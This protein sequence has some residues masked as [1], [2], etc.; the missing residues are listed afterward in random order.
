MITWFS[1][2]FA[3]SSNSKGG[4]EQFDY[5][6]VMVATLL[7]IG[8]T[9]FGISGAFGVFL[10]PLVEDF[11]S[12][13]V[14]TSGIFSVYIVLGAM[15]A[16]L[17]GW[18]LDRYGAKIIVV[19]MG[20]FI[21]LSLSLTSQ[22]NASWQLF[23]SYSLLFAMGVGPLYTLTMSTVSRWFSRRRVLAIGIVGSGMGIGPMI[24]APVSAWLISSYD[25][26]TAYFSMGIIA[27]AI[28]IPCALLLK[29]AP[30]ELAALPE[31]GSPAT[32]KLDTSEQQ[33][34]S[35]REEFSLSQAVKTR[36]F[37]LLFFIWF[38]M[39]F[40]FLMVLT[41]LV[42]HAMD[43]GIT[44]MKAASILSLTTGLSIAGRV[45]ISKVSD[46]IGR[47]QAT[48]GCALLMAGA[49]LFLIQ[50]PNLTVLYLF[51]IVFGLTYGGVGPPIV[52]Q[53]GDI[54]GLRNIGII[55]GVLNVGW[56]AG[57]ASGAALGGYVFDVSGSYVSAFLGAMAAMVIAAVLIL[58][59][60]TPTANPEMEGYH[61]IYQKENIVE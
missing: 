8:I 53:F 56:G 46:I 34:Y 61:G 3:G 26:R 28:I 38:F 49:L 22:A 30:L 21:G 20:F 54:F 47:K 29:K 57:A 44:P 18:A 10:K 33:D 45:M 42:P 32:N 37:W 14:L 11:S 39:A 52:A 2:N 48:V 24:M 51:A 59:V 6:W 7:V 31:G 25:W 15:F 23:I 55:M 1:R 27:F 43:S 50:P 17:G 60:R 16:V 5:G 19:L 12:T 13:R 58:L 4:K 35:G 9:G 40:C 36:N 41:H